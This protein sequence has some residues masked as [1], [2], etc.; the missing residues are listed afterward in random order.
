MPF[1]SDHH[2]EE[3][4]REG[5]AAA[6]VRLGKGCS[7]Q[8]LPG[9]PGSDSGGRSLAPAPSIRVQNFTRCATSAERTDGLRRSRLLAPGT[10]SRY[11]ESNAISPVPWQTFRGEPSVCPNGAERAD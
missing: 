6:V 9:A 11:L 1:S 5:P 3:R 2:R 10:S 4:A 7:A 8:L